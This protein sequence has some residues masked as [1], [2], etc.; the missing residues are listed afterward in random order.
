MAFCFI[1]F[2]FSCMTG[3]P[4]DHVYRLSLK[5]QP[6][7]FIISFFLFSL[8]SL[9]LT[10]SFIELIISLHVERSFP[11]PL[12]SCFLCWEYRPGHWSGLPDLYIS[13]CLLG[14]PIH[15]TP[16][17]VV[18]MP[19]CPFCVFCIHA[20]EQPVCFSL[21]YRPADVS[22]L[23]SSFFS[24]YLFIVLNWLKKNHAKLFLFHHH[25]YI[26][27]YI[28]TYIPTVSSRVMSWRCFFLLFINLVILSC[29][30]LSL[31]S[32]SH[33]LNFLCIHG[34][35]R[36]RLASRGFDSAFGFCSALVCF[37]LRLVFCL[38]LFCLAWSDKFCF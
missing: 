16:S 19:L 31:S 22:C 36:N 34:W 5:S 35:K 2:F 26:Y 15:Y 3:S 30:G 12:L 38:I 8:F 4:F 9:V 6:C 18:L 25:T 7:P 10:F 27:A 11:F 23:F 24:F 1:L 21:F 29:V 32:S 33:T 14:L 17:N 20:L 28:R 13:T 37:C